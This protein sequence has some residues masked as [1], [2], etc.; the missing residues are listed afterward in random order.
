MNHFM[1]MGRSATDLIIKNI[2]DL[3]IRI[4]R[5]IYN[6]LRLDL[7]A[8]NGHIV[9]ELISADKIRLEISQKRGEK[10]FFVLN[11]IN[12]V[13]FLRRSH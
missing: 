12:Q 9:N 4:N 2:Q 3:S 11:N 1:L 10:Y 6:I 7:A 5:E 8:G 13:A